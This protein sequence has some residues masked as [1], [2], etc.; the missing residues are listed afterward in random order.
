M[1][2]GLQFTN[3]SGTIILDSE[4]ARM[5]VVSSGS[6][7]GTYGS[8][9][10]TSIN[11]FPEPITTQEPPLVFARLVNPGSSLVG[12]LGG[13]VPLGSPGNWTGFVCN[14]GTVNTAPP[15]FI[16]GEWF[17][18]R[19]G[20]PAIDQYGMR[21]WD[22]SGQLIFDSGAPTANFTR[23]AQNWSYAKSVQSATTYWQNFYVI[24][25]FTFDPLEFLLIN[26]FGMK[27][28]SSGGATDGRSYGIWWDWP[29]SRIW[30]VTGA[31]SNPYDFHMSALFAK[32]V[33]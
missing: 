23:A 20:V 9:E 31:F 24:D 14:A 7:S 30:A 11:Y 10:L 18:C 1:S 5:C 28:Q 27:L 26:Q 16:N 3:N 22:S 17:A 2:Y 21:L 12:A 32:R 19:F 33:I 4:F 6:L 13:F 15:V 29:A 8:N 25:G